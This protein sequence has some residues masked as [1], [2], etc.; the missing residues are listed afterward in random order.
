MLSFNLSFGQI[1]GNQLNIGD[2]TY[3]WVDQ[4][5]LAPETQAIINYATT[6]GF[7]LPADI[8]PLDQ[9]IK[10]LKTAGIWQKFDV[11]Y[12]FAGYGA[13]GFKLINLIDPNNHYADA[14]GGLEFDLDGVKGNGFNG[15]INTNFNPTIDAINYVLNEAGRLAVVVQEATNTTTAQRNIDGTI[16]GTGQNGMINTLQAAQRINMGMNS[17]VGGSVDFSGIGLMTINEVSAT[18]IMLTNKDIQFD[19][20]RGIS[21][22]YNSPQ[23]IFRRS[24]SYGDPKISCYGM[25][26]ALTYAETQSFRTIYNN[27]LTAIGLTPVA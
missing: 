17:L 14:Y 7:I 13:Y 8:Q 12:V 11:F 10:D 23:T 26:G 20:T 2:T 15:Y 1:I 19:R 25:G 18:D 3:K 27:Y 9:L 24:T 22:L 16:G 5:A 21:S 6:Q 4:S